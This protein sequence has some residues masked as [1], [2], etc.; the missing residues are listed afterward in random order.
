MLFHNRIESK[1]LI[2]NNLI[3]SKGKYMVGAN[4]LVS[5]F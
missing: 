3:E 5:H 1:Y 2:S 4:A